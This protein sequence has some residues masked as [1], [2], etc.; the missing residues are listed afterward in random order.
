MPSIWRWG[1]SATAQPTKMAPRILMAPNQTLPATQHSLAALEADRVTGYQAQQALLPPSPL[2]IGELTLHQEVYGAN[3]LSGDFID[4]F[5]LSDDRVVFYLADVAGHGTAGAMVTGVLKSLCRLLGDDSGAASSAK[6]A[7]DWLNAQLRRLSIAQHATFFFGIIDPKKSV[8]DYC[9]AGHF[10]GT[11]LL[12]D[13]GVRYLATGGQPLGL[14]EQPEYTGEQVA[15]SAA[16]SIV[17]LSDG[18]L[19]AMPQAKLK[20]KERQLLELVRDHCQTREG[21]DG[22]AGTL[23]VPDA[24]DGMYDD[25]AI[26]WLARGLPSS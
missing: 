21:L 12:Q 20:A 26:L 24:A 3:L 7:L 15:L 16:F 19:E 23:S 11:M 25:I 5:E 4:Y 13:G 1:G 9:N 2:K 14:Y 18:I 17:V 8:L 10:P 22:L 6:A